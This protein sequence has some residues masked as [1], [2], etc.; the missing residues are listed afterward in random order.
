MLETVTSGQSC[1]IKKGGHVG[2]YGRFYRS[3]QDLMAMSCRSTD[4]RR[5]QGR[6]I[7]ASKPAYQ[8]L[9][10]KPFHN[11]TPPLCRAA[12]HPLPSYKPPYHHSGS[13]AP[14]ATTPTVKQYPL[15]HYTLTEQAARRVDLH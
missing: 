8:I 1:A 10:T 9:C 11:K 12:T 13:T 7:R 2:T 5:L 3:M 15:F 4:G 14:P 6:K